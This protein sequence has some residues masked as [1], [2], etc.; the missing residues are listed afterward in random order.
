MKALWITK[1]WYVLISSKDH[2]CICY[3]AY[4]KIIVCTADNTVYSNVY[5]NL[6]ILEPIV[7]DP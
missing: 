3:H 2:H 4:E 5:R 6:N 7:I 1:A